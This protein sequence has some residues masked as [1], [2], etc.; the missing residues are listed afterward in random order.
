MTTTLERPD[1]NVVERPATPVLEEHETLERSW[2]LPPFEREPRK[3]TWPKFLAVGLMSGL[4]GLAAGF[5][6]GMWMRSDEIAQLKTEQLVTFTVAPSYVT[7][8]MDTNGM[9]I[10][11]QVAPAGT[12]ERAAPAPTTPAIPGWTYK[13]PGWDIGFPS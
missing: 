3:R 4:V 1:T 11:R 2:Q 7:P 10:T 13:T 12:G 9:P 5:G 6:A 8:R